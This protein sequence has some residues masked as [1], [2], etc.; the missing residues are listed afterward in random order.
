MVSLSLRRSRLADSTHL[1]TSSIDFK[2]F[3]RQQEIELNT[4]AFLVAHTCEQS[5]I[6][7]VYGSNR[8]WSQDTQRRETTALTSKIYNVVI[9]FNFGPVFEHGLERG[10][11]TFRS[12]H[13]RDRHDFVWVHDGMGTLCKRNKKGEGMRRN[14][15]VCLHVQDMRCI[16]NKHPRDVV[17]NTNHPRIRSLFRTFLAIPRIA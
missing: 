14:E 3:A 11:G 15:V 5:P 13:S 10:T 12:F 2:R 7:K 9:K 16:A 8:N 1:P 4:S 17:L 6:L